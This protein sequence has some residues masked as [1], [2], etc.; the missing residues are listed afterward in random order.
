[1]GMNG[2][3]EALVRMRKD[4]LIISMRISELSG[5]S[6]SRHVPVHPALCSIF[7][8]YSHKSITLKGVREH[9][10]DMLLYS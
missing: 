2:Y 9:C 8:S 1:M 6:A 4:S 3:Y 10:A 5:N 7:P